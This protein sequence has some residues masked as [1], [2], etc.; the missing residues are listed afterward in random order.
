MFSTLFGIPS[1][2]GLEALEVEAGVVPLELRREDMAVR[3][4]TKIMAKVNGQKI[5]ECFQ[6]WK[7]TTEEAQEKIMSP[8]VMAYMQLNSTI[9]N[10]CIDI[11]A[12]EPE[13][14]YL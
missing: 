2:A 5:A 1:T 12:V 14:S 7:A 11:R 8:F 9:S 3:E 10:T 6:T 13:L 4:V